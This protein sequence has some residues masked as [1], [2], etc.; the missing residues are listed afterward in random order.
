MTTLNLSISALQRVYKSGEMTPEKLIDEILNQCDQYVD[1]NIWITLFSKEQLQPY[2]DKL[3]SVSPDS[4]PLYGIPFAVKDNIDLAGI[5]TTAAC[6][7][8]EYTPGQTA[9][10]VQRLID[11]GAIPIGKTN[12]D[13][14]ATGINGTRSP[15]GP[16][17][18][19]V[20]PDYISGGSSAGSSISVALGLVTFSL[21]TDTAGS[22]RIPAAFNNL[23]GLKPSRGLLSTTGVVPACRS[24]DC[25]SIFS[26]TVE[27]AESVLSVA[28][29]F[30]GADPYSRSRHDVNNIVR[31]NPII[32]IPSDEFLEFYGD[33]SAA[34]LFEQAIS[35]WELAGATIKKI[36]FTPFIETAK[37]LY[38]GP[39]V[40][41]RYVA[42]EDFIKDNID[43]LLPAIR[44]IIEPGGN[45]SA[46]DA[47]KAQYALQAQ[48]KLAD[49]ILLDVDFVVTPTAPTIYTVDEML[50]DPIQL[51]T[52]LGYYTNFVNLLDYAAL[53]IP[54][55]K[56]DNGLPWGISLFSF[57]FSDN[58]LLQYA[59]QFLSQKPQTLGATD[60]TWHAGELVK[61]DDAI[62][63][64]V[65]GAHLSGMPLN[66]QLTDRGGVL[67]EAT[68]TS[69]NYCFY[70]LAGG[71][72]YR[73]GLVRD[74]TKGSAIHVEVWR[75]PQSQV[76]SFLAGIPHP[77]GLGTVEL[78]NGE[79]HKGF[80]C[81]PAAINGAKDITE[82][83]DWRRYM[84]TLAN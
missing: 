60:F 14:F 43:A 41:E 36:D 30:D 83:G 39:W 76:G 63:L 65:C 50:N 74:E 20:N 69:S 31:D 15:W 40:T 4:L 59:Q 26:L 58:V 80:I 73:P 54:A 47:F 7:E 81:E 56:L 29:G 27:D 77:L 55:G 71:P 37:L 5:P 49:A 11:A 82:L 21:G 51:N 18:N 52:N 75:L 34:K 79:W 2:I 57:A 33:P 28:E 70:A 3:A 45:I 25:V 46:A 8:F 84:E 24:L 35:Q 38:H 68:T 10:V 6:K 19:S 61:S 1:H 22:G 12:L 16:G 13:Q 17:R 42:V 66:H 44:T 72:P 62:N 67:I 48:K 64:V 53:A 32:G 23:I 9:T 78:N